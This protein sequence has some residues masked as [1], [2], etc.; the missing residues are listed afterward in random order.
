MAEARLPATGLSG[1]TA[2][3]AKGAT[4]DGLGFVGV[5]AKDAAGC[6]QIDQAGATDF[7]VITLATFRD[8]ASACYGS[9]GALADGKGTLNA[10][11]S[12]VKKSVAIA[13][14][15][16]DALTVDGTALVRCKP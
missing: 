12:G 2:I 9:F 11:C 16:P 14:S 10:S 13:Q 3:A 15:A 8:G 7:A 4:G 5:W 1:D 6:A